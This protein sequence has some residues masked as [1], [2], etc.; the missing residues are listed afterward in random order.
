MTL[1]FHSVSSRQ[2][3]ALA[4]GTI[5]QADLAL[6]SSGQVSKCL[7][8][9]AVIVRD[10]ENRRHPEAAAGVAAWRLLARV[11][12]EAPGAFSEVIR[13]PSVSAWAGSLAVGERPDPGPLSAIAA[14]AAIRGGLPC[15]VPLPTSM[16]S[17]KTLHLPSLGTAVIPA[18]LRR[19]PGTLRVRDGVTQIEGQRERFVLP[20]RLDADGP[21]WH[22]LSAGLPR[23]G[24]GELVI[25]DSYPYQFPREIR[26]AGPLSAS[27]RGDWRRR[28]AGGLRVLA[29][30]HQRT[31]TEVSAVIRAV[32]PLSAGEDGS[33][34]LTSRLA[35]GGVAL[36]LPADDVSMALTLAHEVQH[37]KLSALMDL[38]PLV[39]GGTAGRYYA[40]W[41]PD[42]RP[43]PALLQGLYAHVE[44]ARFW[45]RRREIAPHP[46]AAWRANVEFARWRSCCA[47]VARSLRGAPELT[48]CG[49][50]FVDGLA[51]VIRAWRND[52]VPPT[53][54][55]QAGRE[56]S[57]HQEKWNIRNRGS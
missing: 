42:P 37:S 36:A 22:T 30:H 51:D 46:D 1:R 7:S 31:A 34:S 43:L 6:L 12:R 25:D 18:S 8:M 17:G 4:R 28:L 29:R 52:Q 21:G 53:A 55:A 2:V 50:L 20:R 41:R 48:N 54:V 33:R 49:A 13:F 19:V 5:S 47:L 3:R 45:R 27:P 56:I 39:H 32:I 35:Y 38:V 14:S 44:V 57:E 40:P 23:T 11:Q 16:L 15:D 24:P 26:L 10:A 9:L